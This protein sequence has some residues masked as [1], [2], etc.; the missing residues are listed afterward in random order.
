MTKLTPV[1]KMMAHLPLAFL[2]RQPQKA[3]VICFGMGTSELAILSWGIH[4]T[5][6]ELVPSVPLVVTFFHPDAGKL[7]RPPLAHIVTDDGRAFLE[8]TVEQ[9]DVITTD[10]PPPVEAA[11]SSLL[12]S[13][14][15][16]AIAKPHLR[17]GGILQQW[18]PGGD[19]VRLP[20]SASPC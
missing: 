6:V 7:L 14:E 10:P 4:A 12:Y 1:T 2:P 20:R 15:F 16:Y 19:R 17:E 3:L 9:Y 5:A 11:G 8:R 13:K 18:F